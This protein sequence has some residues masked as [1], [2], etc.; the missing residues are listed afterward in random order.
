MVTTNKEEYHEDLAIRGQ[1]WIK[2]VPTK[3]DFKVDF[4]WLN[5][6]S[7][8]LVDLPIAGLQMGDFRRA[9]LHGRLCTGDLGWSNFHG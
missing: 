3:M 9:T 7:E 2:S 8:D 1:K 5:I 4:E 6:S